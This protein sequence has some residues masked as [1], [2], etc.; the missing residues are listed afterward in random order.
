MV[1]GLGRCRI[2]IWVK[3]SVRLRGEGNFKD[4]VK[5]NFNGRGRGSIGVG[6]LLGE[7]LRIGKM[8][9]LGGDGKFKG[10]SQGERRFTSKG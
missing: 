3:E 2:G 9:G 4:K 8:V 5:G 6:F 1:W 7:G 10:K